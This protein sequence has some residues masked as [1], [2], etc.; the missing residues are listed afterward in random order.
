[1][2]GVEDLSGAGVGRERSEDA[3]VPVMV[4]G[5]G[6]GFLRFGDVDDEGVLAIGGESGG[7]EERE[8]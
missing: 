6:E 2:V 1:M 5:E 7:E 3:G 8:G 4:G